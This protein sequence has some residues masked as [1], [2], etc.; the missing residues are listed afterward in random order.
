MKYVFRQSPSLCSHSPRSHT[1]THARTHAP[2]RTH[3][4]AR[5]RTHTHSPPTSP[6]ALPLCS[7][8]QYPALCRDFCPIDP[9]GY[10]FCRVPYG[11]VSNLWAS[12]SISPPD[13]AGPLPLIS[14][15]QRFQPSTRK[16]KVGRK[17]GA[18]RTKGLSV[19]RREM[20]DGEIFKVG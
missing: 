20:L 11:H 13:R 17:R 4:H 5:T 15:S 18:G 2:A 8:S 10:D 19:R 9:R 6:P 1:H 16:S 14:S 3:Q 7:P 12:L